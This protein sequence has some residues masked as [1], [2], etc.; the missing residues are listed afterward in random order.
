M[1][2]IYTA[3]QAYPNVNFRYLVKPTM[4]MPG[5]IVPLDFDHK[6]VTQVLDDGYSDAKNILA[7]A[8]STGNAAEV[9]AE[10]ESGRYKGIK[11]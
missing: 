4:K 5:S 2:Y 1:W 3:M 9:I 6:S 10:W 7:N 11:K 8:G